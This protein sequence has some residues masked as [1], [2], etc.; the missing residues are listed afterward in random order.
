MLSYY[1][2]VLII[3]SRLHLK[4]YM[5]ILIDIILILGGEIKDQT[6]IMISGEM[7]NNDINQSQETHNEK[8]DL[9]TTNKE[10]RGKR[11]LSSPGGKSHV[12]AELY[13]CKC[14]C[15]VNADNIYVQEIKQYTCNK[16]WSQNISL[17]KCLLL[18]YISVIHLP[19]ASQTMHDE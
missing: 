17:L 18:L 19:T 15:L 6:T 4:C 5:Y 13:F 8:P 7:M 3:L 14:K 1:T 16:I 9:G 11:L 2:E 12:R 10:G